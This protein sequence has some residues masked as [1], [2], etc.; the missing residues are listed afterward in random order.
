MTGAEWGSIITAAVALAGAAGSW[1]R[2]QAAKAS[3]D[4]AH[5]RINQLAVKN[6]QTSQV[7]KL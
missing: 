7:P 4:A 3:A 5:Q 6:G 2:A 1:L